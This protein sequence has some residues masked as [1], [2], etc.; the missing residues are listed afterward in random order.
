MVHDGPFTH[1]NLVY[2]EAVMA[3]EEFK[4]CNT[5]DIHAELE[6]GPQKN[7]RQTLWQPPP[8]GVTKINCDVAVN[9]K[10]GCIGIGIIARDSQ[11]L[12]VG[13]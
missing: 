12:F 4:T 10:K 3:C 13:A 6:T 11:G 1:P 7:N 8:I 9:N 5:Q 2:R